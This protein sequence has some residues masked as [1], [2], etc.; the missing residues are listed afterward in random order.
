[1]FQFRFPDDESAQSR[2][3]KRRLDQAEL[4]GDSVELAD[5]ISNDDGAV[6]MATATTALP[7]TAKDEPT[8]TPISGLQFAFPE[9]PHKIKRIDRKSTVVSTEDPVSQSSISSMHNDSDVEQTPWQ[10]PSWWSNVSPSK[11]AQKLI[12]VDATQAC[13]TT[14]DLREAFAE[15]VLNT[16][17]DVAQ[18]ADHD[19]EPSK[20]TSDLLGSIRLPDDQPP[21]QQ[22]TSTAGIRFGLFGNDNQMSR[23]GGGGGVEISPRKGKLPY[24]RGGRAELLTR[25]TMHEKT[26]YALWQHALT[27]KNINERPTPDMEATVAEVLQ[28]RP[29]LLL[30]RCI[31]T[32][33]A[34]QR[35][36]SDN[37]LDA[38]PRPHSHSEANDEATFF[39]LLSDPMVSQ[40]GPIKHTLE[41][42]PFSSKLVFIV[43]GYTQQRKRQRKSHRQR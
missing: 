28:A 37:S 24:E 26:D 41:A 7:A 23:L 30:C 2:P 20:T 32:S 25:L 14:Q 4:N 21:E 6:S 18:S 5:S 40:A 39:A 13:C 36:I 22:E 29:G 33:M 42:A 12:D 10:P 16:T 38:G 19:I 15:A 11:Q 27:K 3:P 8:P 17:D 43:P 35:A 34:L 31:T 9:S 1:M